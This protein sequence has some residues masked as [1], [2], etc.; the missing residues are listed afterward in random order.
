MKYSKI[1]GLFLNYE[2]GKR[3][4]TGIQYSSQ[5]TNTAD[6]QIVIRTYENGKVIITVLTLGG[7]DFLDFKSQSDDRRIPKMTG[8]FLNSEYEESLITCVLTDKNI[9]IAGVVT[10][11]DAAHALS[12]KILTDIGSGK[13]L[14]VMQENIELISKSTFDSAIAHA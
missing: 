4:E 2:T 1:V 6:H 11:L 10:K 14:G 7:A 8:R 9:N 13:T 3:I 5:E 12:T